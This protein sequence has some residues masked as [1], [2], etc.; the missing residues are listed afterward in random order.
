MPTTLPRFVEP[1]LATLQDKPPAGEN[2]LHEVK[3][4]GYRLQARIE[5]GKVR[6]ADPLGPRLD[7]LVSARRSP[8]RWAICLATRR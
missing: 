6:A 2:W 1:C 3:F 8:R 7:R 4:D 5:H